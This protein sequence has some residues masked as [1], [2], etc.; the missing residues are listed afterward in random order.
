[1]QKLMSI[2]KSIH[3]DTK[4][5]ALIFTLGILAL[6]LIMAVAFSDTAITERKSSSN[7]SN[8]TTAK[9]LAE[10]AVNRALI[11]MK[12]YSQITDNFSSLMSHSTSGTNSLTYDYLWHIETDLDGIY[13]KPFSDG[14]YN[15][16]SQDAIH[17][18]YLTD[19]GTPEKIIGR[20]A[21]YAKASGGKLDPSA[22]VDSGLISPSY[23]NVFHDEGDL[24]SPK[25]R[26]GVNVNEI[27]LGA[28]DPKAD[29]STGAFGN[30]LTQDRLKGFS[31]V[32]ASGRL[33]N[34]TRWS[35]S[36]SIF[37]STSNTA[38]KGAFSTIPSSIDKMVMQNSLLA[39]DEAEDEECFWLETGS[40]ALP[41]KSQ[42][43]DDNE[44]YHRFNMAKTASEWDAMTVSQL[45]G[46]AATQYYIGGV[47]PTISINIAGIN[48]LT[49]LALQSD[50]HFSSAA[51]MR[52]QIA[53]NIIDYCDSNSSATTDDPNN[54]TYVGLEKCPYI[55]ELQIKVTAGIT[56]DPADVDGLGNHKYKLAL[57]IT[58]D[59]EVIN[60]YDTTII[61]EA[62][63]YIEGSF[64]W[65]GS[66]YTISSKLTDIA[67]NPIIITAIPGTLHN[68]SRK[69]KTVTIPKQVAPDNKSAN[70]YSATPSVTDFKITNL[71]VKL[72]SSGGSSFYDYSKIY[73]NTSSPT[74]TLAT[75]NSIYYDF[76]ANDP[77]QNL[78]IA[79][80][81]IMENGTTANTNTVGS[82]NTSCIFTPSGYIYDLE[83][84]ITEPW[85]VSTAFVRNAPMISP[86]EIGLIHRAEKWRTINLKAYNST[87][88]HFGITPTAGLGSYTDGDSNILDQI[89]FTSNTK[90][91]GLVN[92]KNS[93][94]DILRAL[95]QKIYMP[96]T[97]PT[98]S[99]PYQPK[100][101]SDGATKDTAYSLTYNDPINY[102]AQEV[103]TDKANKLAGAMLN[104]ASSLQTR[105]QIVAAE[106]LSNSTVM[107]SQ[108]NDMQREA[109][110]GKFI[111]LTKVGPSNTFTVIAIAQTIK[112]LGGD[113]T[114]IKIYKDLDKDGSIS[115][116]NVTVKYIVSPN[117]TTTQSP[118]EIPARLG[119]YDAFADE[120]LA[121][122]KII[123]TIRKV[124]ATKW[125]ILNIE[126][127]GE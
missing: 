2:L 52:N 48:W 25:L 13:Y 124:S 70:Y 104:K 4:G 96:Y 29:L 59:I 18:Q 126:Y 64:N 103:T 8:A 22:C 3:K 114:D 83:P 56:M 123:A 97:K 86:M 69:F 72:T 31:S 101:E 9:L 105:A 98:S 16:N 118:E 117:D 66:S 116:G 35:S 120:I 100:F 99:Y 122:Q 88:S 91:W 7:Y 61:A 106:A 85:Q 94:K 112:D 5:V 89:K 50:S 1:M 28:A 15:K 75:G 41:N 87:D 113:G 111:N 39:I 84:N 119:R 110:I 102:L 10:S 65:G 14:V 125:V 45:V 33:D 32:N 77:R 38:P 74:A 23:D 24:T 43:L 57:D 54:P 115:A 73:S 121:E 36:P 53:A 67:E 51:E 109:I 93:N 62:S 60:L 34:G 42:K 81:A 108:N 82:K 46:T 11:A 49:N 26:P 79:D 30:T 37:Y 76:E 92:L 63:V 90:T 95:L 127:T 12:Y 55:N 17:W 40:E 44:K 20:F 58:P 47:P 6:L 71:K 68:Y 21:Y 80:W 27:Y 107:D 19:G 78:N